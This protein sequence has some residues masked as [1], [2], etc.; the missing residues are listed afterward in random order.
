ML[1]HSKMLP[2][3]HFTE[4]IVYVIQGTGYSL[5]NGTR[6]T[7]EQ[8]GIFH[9]ASGITH[10]MFNPGD[11]E[12]KCLLILCPDANTL[13][14]PT[15]LDTTVSFSSQA[16]RESL[17]AAIDN[18][19]SQFLDSMYCSYVIFDE[20][21]NIINHS[22]HFPSYCY[23]LCGKSLESDCSA[24]MIAHPSLPFFEETRTRCPH[25]L[26]LIFMPVITD[27]AFLGFVEGGFVR[28]SAED[29]NEEMDIFVASI[30]AI[31]GIVVLLH[32]IVKSLA[33]FC[34]FYRMKQEQQMQ[35]I[36][37]VAEQHQQEL[38]LA[39][40][41]NA[42]TL[43][44]DLKIN[45]HFLFNTLNHMASIALD[46]GIFSLYQSIIDLS[47]LFR[48]TLRNSG[49]IISLQ[50]E[51]SSL[52]AYL[53]LQKLR[54][55]DSLVLKYDIRTELEQ[56]TVPFNILMP[57]AENAFTHGFSNIE[58]K[59]ITIR[60]FE[61]DT[62]L[63]LSVENNGPPID[64]RTCQNITTGMKLPTNHGLS[65]IYRKLQLYYG[66][67]FSMSFLSDSTRGTSVNIDIP[68]M[69][70]SQILREL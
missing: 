63:H 10:E 31:K 46:N 21:G 8:G 44:T 41:R 7:T 15:P 20:T 28:T 55:G 4:Q 70:Q 19:R 53:K 2:H 12:F 40:L 5:I 47:L 25:G 9:W 69:K 67:D 23:N 38:L 52:Y 48:H 51:I 43:M 37:L 14:T 59:K 13:D 50:D 54:Y 36:A 30:S 49:A 60:L 18:L 34:E 3:I 39:D 42:E 29:C 68:P 27:G 16:K 32:R 64:A 65:M 11:S 6:V 58:I 26:T 45:N 56:W 35:N 66:N 1:P 57:L 17:L 62:R 24:C 22:R 61:K 33:V